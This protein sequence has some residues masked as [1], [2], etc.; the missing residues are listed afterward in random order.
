MSRNRVAN[1]LDAFRHVLTENPAHKAGF[2]I[3]RIWPVRFYH[4]R[5]GAC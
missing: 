2:F 5:L 3:V 1:G 4:G